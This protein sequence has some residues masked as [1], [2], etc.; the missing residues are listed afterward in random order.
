M[1]RRRGCLENAVSSKPKKVKAAATLPPSH[2]CR[3]P[4][5]MQ[6]SLGNASRCNSARLGWSNLDNVIQG[7]GLQELAIRTLR[8]LN[9]LRFLAEKASTCWS[10][11]WN[12]CRPRTHSNHFKAGS[13]TKRTSNA[14][15]RHWH[16]GIISELPVP[17]PISQV[18][19]QGRRSCRD[20]IAR[21][22]CIPIN[23]AVLP[24]QVV[25]LPGHRG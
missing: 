21:R 12:S 16:G 10:T 13:A 8:S 1:S 9:D 14:A 11:V 4:H 6:V 2:P 7:I 22:Q 25:A 20:D 3:E 19:D 15:A 23:C 18:Q 17:V 24:F 5:V